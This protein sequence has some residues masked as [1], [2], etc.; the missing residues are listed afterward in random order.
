MQLKNAFD[1]F[2]RNLIE[3]D[4]RIARS[5]VFVELVSLGATKQILSN[6]SNLIF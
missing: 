5:L 2:Q 3:R 4:P 6:A 1:G